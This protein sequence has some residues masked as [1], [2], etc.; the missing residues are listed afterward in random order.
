MMRLSPQLRMNV[1]TR[2]LLYRDMDFNHQQE[3][4]Q[5]VNHKVMFESPT[6]CS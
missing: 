4:Q 3:K 2:N 6:V 1:I 5:D